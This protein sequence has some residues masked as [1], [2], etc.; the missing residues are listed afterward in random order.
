MI[1]FDGIGVDPRTR[2]EGGNISFPWPGDFGTRVGGTGLAAIM[3][4]HAEATKADNAVTE[5]YAPA[6]LPVSSRPTLLTPSDRSP[7]RS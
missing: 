3:F 4:T 6:T 5:A 7:P 2:S 1:T